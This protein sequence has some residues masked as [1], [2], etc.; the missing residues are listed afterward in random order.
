MTPYETFEEGALYLLGL[1][2]TVWAPY[3]VV[4]Y[5]AVSQQSIN[6]KQ[7]FRGIIQQ[8]GLGNITD[9]NFSL[10]SALSQQQMTLINLYAK[11]LQTTTCS[12]I[13]LDW[14]C[15]CPAAWHPPTLASTVILASIFNMDVDEAIDNKLRSD[16]VPDLAWL[17]LPPAHRG[18]HLSEILALWQ[19][20][21]YQGQHEHATLQKFW[22]VLLSLCEWNAACFDFKACSFTNTMTHTPVTMGWLLEAIHLDHVTMD[23]LRLN[24]TNSLVFVAKDGRK[25]GKQ[26]QHEPHVTAACEVEHIGF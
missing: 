14:S 26:Q 12:K 13:P 2:P 3:G 7:P 5:M 8:M 16:I 25:C 9:T 15:L 4:V 11:Q 23:Q 17:A 24:A 19:P 6:F 18:R 21:I 1:D 20:V 22:G 10:P